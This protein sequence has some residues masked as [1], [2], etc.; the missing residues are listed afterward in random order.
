MGKV[1]RSHGLFIGRV[2]AR[3]LRSTMS[4]GA[5]SNSSSFSAAGQLE[6]GESIVRVFDDRRRTGGA[7]EYLCRLQDGVVWEGGP[8]GS[9]RQMCQANIWPCGDVGG[10]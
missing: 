8:V 2:S 3:T 4:Q 1:P 10:W 9:G 6:E 5:R 7:R